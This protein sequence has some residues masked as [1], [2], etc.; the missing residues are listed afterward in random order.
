V[1]PSYHAAWPF[2]TGIWNSLVIAMDLGGFDVVDVDCVA[3]I[4]GAGPQAM[5]GKL[6]EA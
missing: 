6:M 4:E 5:Q 2:F 3:S 1:S